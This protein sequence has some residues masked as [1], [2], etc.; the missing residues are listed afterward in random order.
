MQ[1]TLTRHQTRRNESK[2]NETSEKSSFKSIDEPKVGRTLLVKASQNNNLEE[3][4]FNAFDGL[5]SKFK[6]KSDNSYFL[7]FN[8]LDNAQKAYSVLNK[9]AQ[10]RVKYS[11]YRT[12]FTMKGLTPES[13]YNQVKKELS[14]YVK[15]KSG[16]DVL[17]CKFYR[18]DNNYIGC[19]D[20]TV[21]TLE[22][23]NSL[24]NNEFSFSSYSGTFYRYNNSN[25]SKKQ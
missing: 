25:N 8:T 13:D 16:C 4:D 17:Y 9:N 18:K 14:D 19:G 3:S 10:L 20:L 6:T 21:D 11:Y 7:T 22:G 15:T 1:R 23:M 24:L 2:Q 12:F 5:L